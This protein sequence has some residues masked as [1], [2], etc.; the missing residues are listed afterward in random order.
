MLT[1][2]IPLPQNQAPVRPPPQQQQPHQPPSALPPYLQRS[3][4]VAGHSSQPPSRSS[5]PPIGP[6]PYRPS[7]PF[8][9][10]PSSVPPRPHSPVASA[11]VVVEPIDV[12]LVVRT[13][14][15]SDLHANKPFSV[16]CTLGVSASVREGQQ[17][18]LT[19]AVQH[20]QPPARPTSGKMGPPVPSHTMATRGR[21]ATATNSRLAS[22]VATAIASSIAPRSSLTLLDGPLVGSPRMTQLGEHEEDHHDR[23]LSSPSLYRIPPPEPMSG[24]ETRYEKLRGATRFLGA[25]TVLVPP[26]T[27]ARTSASADAPRS[28]SPSGGGGGGGDDPPPSK[29]EQFWDF[30]LEYT[31][32]K[33]GFV[34]V[35][36]LRVLLLEDQVHS[37]EDAYLPERRIVAPVVL[38]E[39]DVIGEIWVKS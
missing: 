21:T 38:K 17:R 36:G 13:I 18:T 23:P 24:D 26:M 19:L 30:E 15:R 12:D 5:T 35:G 33:T 27:L 20:V 4:T 37:T 1:R 8:R 7:S 25:S 31:P 6:T 11:S 3:A 34:L 14:P 10:R 32:L 22:A 28:S 9:N 2:R 16:A 29:E 39:W